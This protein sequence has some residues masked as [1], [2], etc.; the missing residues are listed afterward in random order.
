MAEFTLPSAEQVEKS[1]KTLQERYNLVPPDDTTY[2][3]GPKH[4]IAGTLDAGFYGF[5]K[6]SEFGSIENNAEPNN[7]FSA[8]NLALAL[9]I[10][11]GEP[12]YQDTQWLKFSWKGKVLITPMRVIRRSI[13]WESIY[14]AGAVFGT[15]TDISEGEQFMLDN[16]KQFTASNDRVPQNA[17]V[18]IGGVEY[19]VRLMRGSADNPNRYSDANRGAVGPDNEWNRLILPLHENAPNSFSYNNYAGTPTED[20][21]VDLTDED[22]LT[23]NSFGQGSYSWMQEPSDFIAASD[24]AAL[25]P[26]RRLV[27]GNH[28]ASYV[29]AYSSTNAYTHSGWRPVLELS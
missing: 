21:G 3:P 23:R 1:I 17:T 16:D 4:L 7:N 22:L 10:T 2:A 8:E 14:L 6:R 18:T 11:Q 26:I 27:R 28:G 29:F 15:G 9:G 13:S 19:K 20:W 12:I 5:I 24:D 25:G